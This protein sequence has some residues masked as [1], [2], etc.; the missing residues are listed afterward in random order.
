MGPCAAS[1]PAECVYVGDTGDNMSHHATRAIY[2]IEEPAANGQTDSVAAEQLTYVYADGAHDVEAM[3]VAGNGDILLIT[4]RMLKNAAG[5]PREA[6][7]FLLPRAA[8]ASRDTATAQLVDS[9][10]IIPGSAVLRTITDAALSSDGRHLAVR[11]Y[12]QVYIY[13][14]DS[15]TGRANHAMA[16][17]VCNLVALGEAQ[18]EGVTWVDTR[19][20]LLFTSEGLTEPIRLATC[21][22]PDR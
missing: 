17:T 21:P 11:T 16:P 20:R 8:W 14:A 18:G 9:L 2:R 5:M 22:L 7:V 10:S 15:L 19:G 4:K 13:G 3:Y 12:S 6:L 1:E